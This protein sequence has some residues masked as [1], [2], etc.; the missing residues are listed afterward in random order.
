MVEREVEEELPLLQPYEDLPS[1][2]DAKNQRCYWFSVSESLF[3]LRSESLTRY[4]LGIWRRHPKML[5]REHLQ[6][7]ACARARS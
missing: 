6:R 3:S 2:D 4:L 7:G 1:N 5:H